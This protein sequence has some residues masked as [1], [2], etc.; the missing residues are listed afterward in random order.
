MQ[1][2]GA[3]LRNY[4]EVMIYRPEGRSYERAAFE[5]SAAA[6][7]NSYLAVNNLA[8]AFYKQGEMAKAETSFRQAVERHG[9]GIDAL[10]GLRELAIERLDRAA[11]RD[12]ASRKARARQG[13]GANRE[14]LKRAARRWKG[15]G[16][17][18][19]AGEDEP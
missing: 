6:G 10:D 3:G 4:V 8:W 18:R 2:M 11:V 13:E 14:D 17:G 5:H 16:D 1:Q 15:T 12:V 9:A 19:K 7:K